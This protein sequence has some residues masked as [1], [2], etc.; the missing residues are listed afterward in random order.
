MRFDDNEPV[1]RR[2]KWGTNHYEYNPRN[3]VGLALTVLTITVVGVM[4]LLM[5]NHAGPFADPP[6]PSPSPWSPPPDVSKWAPPQYSSPWPTSP[7]PEYP[8]TP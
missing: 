5:H 2:S 6:E 3:P 7:E 4:L 8:P 1:F